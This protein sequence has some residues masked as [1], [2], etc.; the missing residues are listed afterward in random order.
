MVLRV[1]EEILADRQ[2]L[3][4]MLVDPSKPASAAASPDDWLAAISA[5]YGAD[6]NDPA[7]LLRRV[8]AISPAIALAQAAQESGWGRS[9]FA[10]EGNALFGQRIWTR[11]AGLV[12]RAAPNGSRFAVR[13]FPTLL[14]SVRAYALNLNSHAAYDSYRRQREAAGHQG[15]RLDPIDAAGTLVGYSEDGAAY[16]NAIREILDNNMLADFELSEIR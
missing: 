16:V 5:R 4:R 6:P 15:R 8:D 2:L 9:R 10:Q 7:D 11:E 13:A 1:N 14:D 3:E 12:A